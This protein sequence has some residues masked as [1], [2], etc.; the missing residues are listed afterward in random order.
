MLKTV[1]MSCNINVY[2]LIIHIIPITIYFQMP[3]T[4][5][6][7]TIWDINLMIDSKSFHT[8]MIFDSDLYMKSR[9]STCTT[10]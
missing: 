4:D 9:I 6:Q 10:I 3:F 2:L 1:A 5:K 7:N 8:K